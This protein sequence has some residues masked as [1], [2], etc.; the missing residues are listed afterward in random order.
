MTLDRHRGGG[1]TTRRPA[2]T[3][4]Q[5]GALSATLAAN[6]LV[7][8]DQTSV[9]VALPV[10]GRDLDARTSALQ[11]TITV[12][13]LALAVFMPAAGRLADH[14]GRRRTFLVGL[15]VFGTGAAL[16]ALAPS[17]PLLL[18]ARFVQG[19]GGAVVQP[20]A[21][22]TTTRTVGE[23]QRGW[24]IGLLAT[25]GTS[26]LTLGPVLSGALLT[27]GWRT[28]FL[29]NLPVVAFAMLATARWVTPSVENEPRPI[30]WLGL[31][32]LLPGLAALVLGIAGAAEL[33]AFAGLAV[34]AGLVTIGLFV[35]VERRSQNPLIDVRLLGDPNLATCLGALF[36]IQF[37]VLGLTVPLAIYLQRGLGDSA[38]TAGL[39][40]AVA[41]IG[42]PLLSMWS[43][44]LADRHGARTLVIPGLTLAAVGLAAVAVAAGASGV[45]V[46][47]PGLLVFTVARPMVFTPA[48]SVPFSVLGR[49]RRAF[50]ASLAT[51]SRQLG[52]MLGVALGSAALTVV[53]GTHLDQGDPTLVDGF[54]TAV[55][56][57]AGVCAVVGLV[58]WRWMSGQVRSPESSPGPAAGQD[59][60]MRAVQVSENGGPEV[61]RPVELPEPVVE[62]GKLLVAVTAAGVN[63]IDTYHRSGLYS[64]PLP[65]VPGLE[66]VGRVRAVGDGVT[67]FDVGDRVAWAET[68][69]SYAELVAVPAD[70]AVPVPDGVTDEQAVGALLQG[71]TAH[72]LVTDTYPVRPGDDVLVHAAAGGVGLLLTQ[73][74]TARGARVIGT[75]S[76]PEKAELARQAGAAEV[77]FYADYATP[78]A[79]AA[80]VREL[81]G[82]NGVA[83]AYDAVGR[84][85][86]DASLASLRRRGMLVLY[87]QSSGP[88]PPV[89]PMRLSQGSLYLTRPVLFHYIA[90]PE[91]LR[92]R[93]AAVYDAVAKGSL[94]VRIGGRYP[95]TDARQAHEDLQARRTTGKLLLIP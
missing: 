33:G 75:V 73:L 91:E 50:A 67:G 72:A 19:V 22:S 9:T 90:T 59:A 62:P 11:W 16:C 79:F 49:E 39:V 47:V 46:L 60:V 69:G 21:L 55:A 61:L 1:S 14:L 30:D 68:I 93:A 81:T 48:G 74:A 45:W 35:R 37:A 85:T 4:R 43:G 94:T 76:T 64:M 28:L 95:L 31:T 12:Y 20:L 17:L 63:Y 66:G 15:G 53:H 34:L 84:D 51:E 3:A 56:V 18:A 88:V 6:A 29:V 36:A 5:R 77:L 65:Y 58:A 54:R 40:I 32:V 7:F 27:F 71:M 24:A 89:D 44:R 80:A 92:A 82:G 42:T 2:L 26:M 52:A 83:A 38:F 13:L 87:G 8:F 86:F 10:I 23:D 41:G 70:K 57:A 25:G 78:D